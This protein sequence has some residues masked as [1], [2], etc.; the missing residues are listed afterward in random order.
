M[1]SASTDS[2]N[3]TLISKPPLEKPKSFMLK[4]YLLD[5]L[6]SCSSNG[7]RSF[8]RRQ[9]CTTTV[10]FL[11]E[12]DLKVKDTSLTKRFLPRTTSRKIALSTIS[13]L[14]RASDAVLRAF[15]QFPLPSS[16]KSFLPR[17]ISRKL[18][19]KA[20][21]KKS[22][23]VDPNT[24]RW[25]SFK[26]FLDEK[27]PPSSDLNRSDSA[28]CTA[29]AVAGRNSTS[30]C[31]NSISW[32]ESEFTS[33]MIPSSSSGNSESCSEN[34]AVKDD[35]DSP[36]NLIGKRDGVSFGKDS[37]EDTTTAPAAAAAATTG[38]RKDIVKQWQND[39]EKEQLSPVSVLDF[40]FEDEDQDI[41]SSFNCNINL[42]EGKKQ[43][44]R[45]KSKRLEKGM[46]LEPVDLKKRFTD[47]SVIGQ[48]FTLITKKEHQMEEK[49]FEFLKLLKSTT[50]STENLL[51]DFFHQKLE[52]HEATATNSD[53][54]QA[55]LLKFT[56]N[57]IDG[58]AGD[59]MV[60]GWE[61]PEERIFYIKDMEVAGKWTSFAGE[62]EELV[63][64]F[65][66][67]VWISLFNDLLIDLSL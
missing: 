44:H 12:I 46:E 27:E 17:S 51:L 15:K 67:E 13:T 8:P 59:M 6:S 26:E 33:E 24:R 34:D 35:K 49:A 45:E 62:K 38:Y 41:S 18:I 1:A 37:M 42:V 65:E 50:K 30:S 66:A 64:E 25:K 63:A 57:W 4:D 28:V 11:L 29:I 55:H 31:S 52:E 10:R 40:P 14:Q 43:K 47:I 53:F 56:Q 32:T 7:F 2:S 58:D 48:H 16:R 60:M 39:E 3:W 5:D 9:C 22:E 61:S 54:D 21:W 20:F 19:S 23:I 36:G